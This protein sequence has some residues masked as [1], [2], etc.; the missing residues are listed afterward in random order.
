MSFYKSV[1]IL[2]LVPTSFTIVKGISKI[3]KEIRKKEK[4]GNRNKRKE[5]I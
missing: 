2:K 5:G 3:R 4:E 1:E